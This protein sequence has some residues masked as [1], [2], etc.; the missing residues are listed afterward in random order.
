MNQHT[1]FNLPLCLTVEEDAFMHVDELVSK[2][3]PDINGQKTLLITE[4]FLADLYPDKVAS[5]QGDFSGADI[6]LVENASYDEAMIIAK[7][8]C[9]EDYKI[10]VGFGGGRVLDTAKYAAYVSKAVYICLP[11]TLS[12]DSLASPFSVL[13]TEGMNRKTLP[14][15]IP[16]A[17][18]VDTTMII[19]APVGQTLSGIGDTLA[20]HTALYDW[21]LAAKAKGANIDDFAYAIAGMS[22][23]S[24]YHCDDKNIKSHTFISILSR[25]LVMGGLAMEIADSSRPCSGSEHLFGH[26]IEEYYPELKISHGIGVALGSIGACIF[27]GRDETGIMNFMKTYG[28]STNPADYGIT[29]DIFAD[30]WTRARGTRPGR[31]TI[32]DHTD[33]NREWL[34][35]IYDR[36][37]EYTNA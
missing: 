9:V 17:I 28:I 16:A 10:V 4:K 23:D 6:W 14:C 1:R 33:L 31:I 26:A 8:L 20:K 21:Q 34:D 3:I 15:K 29:K 25:S 35:E 19:N 7:K 22:F 37:A 30:L 27:Q 32:L 11:T 36:M 13:Q 12:N 24:V 2:Y 18:V 5:I